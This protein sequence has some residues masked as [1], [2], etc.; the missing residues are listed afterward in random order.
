[1]KHEVIRTVWHPEK[2]EKPSCLEAIPPGLY[3]GLITAYQ[4]GL[5]RFLGECC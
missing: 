1:M 3:P 5:S 2:Q 4:I